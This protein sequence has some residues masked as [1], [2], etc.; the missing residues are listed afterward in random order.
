[1]STL[2][3]RLRMAYYLFILASGLAAGVAAI[4]LAFR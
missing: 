2:E 1:M 4:V 3:F